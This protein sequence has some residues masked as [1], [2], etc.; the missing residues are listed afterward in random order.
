[1][2]KWIWQ[3][4]VLTLRT[5]ESAAATLNREATVLIRDKA[6]MQRPLNPANVF[7]SAATSAPWLIRMRASP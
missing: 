2:E 5:S 3:R 4:D 1:M 7:S 6:V